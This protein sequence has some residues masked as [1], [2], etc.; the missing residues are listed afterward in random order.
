L[1]AYMSCFAKS[2]KVQV[3]PSNDKMTIGYE[4]IKANGEQ[5]I[6][7]YDGRENPNT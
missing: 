6:R 1:D 2:D 4:A 5:V 3:G 7:G